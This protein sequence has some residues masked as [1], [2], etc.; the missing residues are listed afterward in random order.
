M[1]LVEF[2][3]AEE[4]S[5]LFRILL[6]LALDRNAAW[7]TSGTEG[8]PVFYGTLGPESQSSAPSIAAFQRGVGIDGPLRVVLNF[9]PGALFVVLP[10][11]LCCDRPE[12]Y[13]WPW[14]RS[15]WWLRPGWTSRLVIAVHCWCCLLLIALAA[16]GWNLGELAAYVA[17]FVVLGDFIRIIYIGLSIWM[18]CA[19][20]ALFVW[21]WTLRRSPVAICLFLLASWMGVC[22]GW[23][24][25][26][27]PIFLSQVVPVTGVSFG[28]LDQVATAVAGVITFVITLSDSTGLQRHKR[29][30]KGWWRATMGRGSG[31]TAEDLPLH[32]VTDGGQPARVRTL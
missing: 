7:D 23:A 11:Y 6:N 20:L 9:V 13:G 3:R 2:P 12:T 32:S 29:R 16:V 22:W 30:L 31:G 21:T 5:H 26:G 4:G 24:S 10:V 28:E 18:G 1:R 17:I 14:Q 19:A 8:E 25:S 27:L 15:E